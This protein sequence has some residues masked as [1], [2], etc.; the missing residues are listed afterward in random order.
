[1]L[2]SAVESTGPRRI[3]RA[4]VTSGCPR[5]VR[6]ASEVGVTERREARM[7][8][9]QALG[10]PVIVANLLVARVVGELLGV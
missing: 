9:Q 8:L 1:M 6:D 2:A 5:P 4:N 7:A 10:V 3:A